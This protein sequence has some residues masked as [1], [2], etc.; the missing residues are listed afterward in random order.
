MRQNAAGCS[1]ILSR[2]FFLGARRVS[3]IRM[4]WSGRRLSRSRRHFKTQ[5]AV[6][7]PQQQGNN[8]AE[9]S[10]IPGPTIRLPPGQVLRELHEEDR[11][12]QK[13][14][15]RT[16]RRFEEQIGARVPRS[17]R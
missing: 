4:G 5:V 11:L 12:R 6:V 9:N 8:E 16:E 1:S 15:R 13:A 2:E 10:F 7:L 17:G 3:W 14:Y